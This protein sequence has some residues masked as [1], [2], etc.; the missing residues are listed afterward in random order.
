MKMHL[1][2]TGVF[3]LAIQ[4]LLPMTLLAAGGSSAPDEDPQQE[5]AAAYNRGLRHRDKAWEFE[6]KLATKSEEAERAKLE[7][8]IGKE[9]G[10]AIDAFRAATEANP[11]MH[12]AYSSLGYALRK[13]GDY[14]ASLAAY[15]QALE[16][17]PSY[18]E[19][20]EY[21]GEA[22]LGLNRI[23][24]AKEAYL[25]L[26]RSDRARADELMEAMKNW[27]G[28]RTAEPGGVNPAELQKFSAW[29]EERAAIAKQTASLVEASDRTWD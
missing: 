12:Q 28:E 15:N 27:V 17:E 29:V 6:K 18:S 11:K 19:A 24:D 26:F 22:F 4:L 3:L 2:R 9:Y 25:E 10:K 5:A 14:T 13:T 23:E 1:T 16:L 20:I 8:K 21:R 7:A